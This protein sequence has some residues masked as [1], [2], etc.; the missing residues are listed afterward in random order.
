[1]SCAAA[2]ARIARRAVSPAARNDS[3]GEGT[4]RMLIV[5][6]SIRQA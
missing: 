2:V 3:P 4:G 1:M 5:A 6:P